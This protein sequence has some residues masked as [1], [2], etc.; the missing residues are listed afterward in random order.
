MT[1]RSTNLFRP[2]IYIS[3]PMA[4]RPEKN[5]ELFDECAADLRSKGWRVE[6]PAEHFGGA[7]DLPR[8]VFL[9]TDI[10]VLMTYA[11]AICLLPE[12]ETSDGAKLE[13]QIGVD[14]LYDFFSWDPGKGLQVEHRST[15]KEQLSAL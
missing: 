13:A 4:G 14:R 8:H 10:I 2:A 11:R 6:N 9:A 5:H 7:L 1:E 3:G 15:I 12:W